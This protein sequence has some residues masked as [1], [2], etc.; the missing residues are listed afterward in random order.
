VTEADWLAYTELHSLTQC[1][2]RKFNVS[3]RKM[4]LFGCACCRP[5]LHLL[6]DSRSREAV[7]VAECY[8]D[9]L[10]TRKELATAR[11]A[12]FAAV[13]ALDAGGPSNRLAARAAAKCAVGNAIEAG[14]YASREAAAEIGLTRFFNS[15]GWSVEH[16]P[17][18]LPQW[19][20]IVAAERE[21][22]PLF[23]DIFGN[24]FRP[25]Q[26][27]PAWRT[28]TAVTIAQVIYDERD[29][30]M[31]PVLADALEDGGCQNADVLSHCRQTGEHVRGCWVVDLVL[32]K[33]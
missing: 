9:G 4:R 15:G 14:R 10:A 13:T 2:F 21:Q 29:F 20:A 26:F 22:I 23:R 1:L 7:E 3:A 18:T 16:P 8:A 17:G 31:L 5:I 12:A 25:V 19:E 27:D 33:E 32:G 24:P 11:K 30:S 28:R 6:K